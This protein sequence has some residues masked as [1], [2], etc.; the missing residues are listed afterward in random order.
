MKKEMVIDK[1]EEL[2]DQIQR[3]EHDQMEAN[4][5]QRAIDAINKIE[6]W[7]SIL[8]GLPDKNMPVY[9]TLEYH[10]GERRVEEA[11]YKDGEFLGGWSSLNHIIK[12]WQPR[13]IPEPYSERG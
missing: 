2:C 4:G 7:V 5:V 3:V 6:S 11:Y 12:A 9:A 1:L 10:G 8:D 13:Y